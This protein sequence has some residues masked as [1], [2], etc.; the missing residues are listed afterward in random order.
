[1]P[2]R[3]DL[4]SYALAAIVP[5]TVLL[6]VGF[7]LP[8]VS[9]RGVDIHEGIRDR[10]GDASAWNLA[11]GKVVLHEQPGGLPG[12]LMGAD[13]NVTARRKWID[14]A[15]APRAWFGL[16]LVVPVVLLGVCIAGLARKISAALSGR[17]L[18]VVALGGMFL[19]VT[20][21]NVDFAGYADAETKRLDERW[22]RIQEALTSQEPPPGLVTTA[23]ATRAATQPATRPENTRA[24]AAG[25]ISRDEWE[26]Y[27]QRRLE[28]GTQQYT[29]LRQELRDGVAS[30]PLA[31]LWLSIGMYAMV[32]V[33]GMIAM[34]QRRC[35]PSAETESRADRVQHEADA[36]DRVET[37]DEN[38]S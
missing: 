34:G 13:A 5:L 30:T 25:T 14:E 38:Q 23:P 2:R 11:E 6:L 18:A 27:Q 15:I 26:Q 20:A 21:M 22:N 17:I 7:F 8:W 12:R 9:L 35:P 32:V 36:T 33:C 16:G 4:P 37:A 31:T 1:M 29:L 28:Q 24:P 10:I 19:C 3:V